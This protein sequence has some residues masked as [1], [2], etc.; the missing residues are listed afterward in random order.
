MGRNDNRMNLPEGTEEVTAAGVA[1]NVP[2]ST[3]TPQFNWTV[4]TEIVPLPS[5]GRFYPDG[6]PL[7]GE[8]TAEIRFMT[9]KDEDILTSR[10]LLKEGL[11]IDRLLQNILVNKDI[12]VNSLLVGDKNALIVAARITGYGNEYNTNVT[13]PSCDTVGEYSFELSV[14]DNTKDIDIHI[15]SHEATRTENN[16]FVVELPLTK[17]NV[18]CRLLTGKDELK[19]AKEAQRRSKKKQN[20]TTL[21]SQLKSFIVS[22]NGDSNPLALAA[23]VQTLPARDS[24]YLRSFYSDITPNLDMNQVYECASCGYTADMEVPLTADFFWP[25]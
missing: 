7:H 18:E 9:A 1:T 5:Q 8:T 16:T 10:A 20:E 6:H 23:F 24:R 2:P 14:E 3:D 4:P 11:A 21:T 22:V 12:E 15:E 19:L 17:A 13:C 25:K